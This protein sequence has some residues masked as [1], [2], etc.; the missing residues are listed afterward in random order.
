M[1]RSTPRRGRGVES[2]AGPRTY[3]VLPTTPLRAILRIATTAGRY[4]VRQQPMPSSPEI[5]RRMQRQAQGDTD[6]ELALRRELWHRGLRYRVDYRLPALRRRADVAFPRQMV[7]VFVDGCFWHVCPEHA[8]WPKANAAWWRTKLEA[9]VR[10]D[11]D[12]DRRLHEA[13]W[14]TIRVWEHDRPADAADRIQAEV[15]ARSLPRE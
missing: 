6:P 1:S 10:R 2:S 12:T 14:L 13:G 5:R 8:S 3:P 9:N 7:A 11:R 4:D 15:R